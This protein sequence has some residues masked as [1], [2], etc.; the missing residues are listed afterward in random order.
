MI[1]AG[2]YSVQIQGN[3]GTHPAKEGSTIFH[4]ALSDADLTIQ[5][6]L[7]VVLLAKFPKVSFFSEE[8]E[9]SLNAKYFAEDSELEILLDPVDGTRSY[10]DNRDHFQ[11]I[12]TIHDRTEI[13]GVLCYMPR[14][15]R[16]YVAVKGEGAFVL[17][18]AEM[19]SG[20]PG[21]KVSVTPNDGPILLFNSPE[22]EAILSSRF[23]VKD[24]A[25]CYQNGSS[26]HDSTDL[27]DNKASAIVLPSCQA[28]DGGALAFVAQEAGAVVC[29][30]SGQPMGNFRASP[31]RVLHNIIVTADP[32]LNRELSRVLS[33]D[34][35]S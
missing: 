16:C 1:P 29:D 3:I 20:A 22:L 6:F 33:G 27:L 26:K 15:D 4:H 32:E 21:T 2:R 11:I 19:E 24:L 35:V 12:V 9:H 23:V 34:T 5:S 30:F 17:S 13:V 7:E 31:K 10:I 18:T 28:I 14:R 25:L 8:G